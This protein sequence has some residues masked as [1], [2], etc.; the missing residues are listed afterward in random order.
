MAIRKVLQF[1]D[2]QLRLMCETITVFDDALKQLVDDMFETVDAYGGGGLAAAQINVQ[3]RVFVMNGGSGDKNVVACINPEI[4]EQRHE[5][6]TE[7]ACYSFPGISAKV[8]R[9]LWVRVKFQDITGAWKELE[10]KDWEARCVHHEIEHL[11]GVVFIDHLSGLKRKML[12]EK[13]RKFKQKQ[14]IG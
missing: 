12:L 1:P 11:D 4:I 5:A 6:V 14:Q 9:P 8:K 7:E 3:Q 10:V 2:E 13:M